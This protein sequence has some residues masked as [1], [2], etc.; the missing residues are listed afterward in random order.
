MLRAVAILAVSLVA[1]ACGSK[2][3]ILSVDTE[4]D[5]AVVDAVPPD[6]FDTFPCRWSYG[7]P[8]LLGTLG[9]DEGTWTNLDGAVQGGADT[10]WVHANA[11][12]GPRRVDQRLSL[13][14]PPRML[15]PPPADVR[16]PHLHGL[17][18]GWASLADDCSV[19]FFDADGR[20]RRLVL[21]ASFDP[22]C[23][24]SN[25]S[26]DF[27][28]VTFGGATTTVERHDGGGGLVFSESIG[29]LGLP[30]PSVVSSDGRFLIAFGSVPDGN[31]LHLVSFDTR[32]RRQTEAEVMTSVDAPRASTALDRLRA[33]A[34]FLIE[35]GAGANLFRVGFDPADFS[36]E[37]FARASAPPIGMTGA[38]VTNETEALMA[39]EGGVIAI[40]P[41]S[42]SAMRSL[43]PPA[44]GITDMRILLSPGESRGGVLYSYVD[45]D[46]ATALE[47]RMLV[48]NR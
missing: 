32:T 8:I 7:Q 36:P 16:H 30:S 3:G 24:L 9:G 45:P 20:A 1:S 5:S 15:D 18:D 2:T 42:G 6:V 11:S 29:S 31:F 44:P 22:P 10:V 14:D 48:C 12:S 4:M 39:L 43:D 25:L 13:S 28:D 34:L 21:P 47:F 26:A 40:Q 37:V 23:V 35:D 41:L 38:L 27:I 19:G 17:A 46:A 33:A